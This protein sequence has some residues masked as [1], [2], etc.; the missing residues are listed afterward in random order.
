MAYSEWAISM[1]GYHNREYSS[2]EKVEEGDVME[3]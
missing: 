2:E 1:V 3:G